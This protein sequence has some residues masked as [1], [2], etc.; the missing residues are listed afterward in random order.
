M[1]TGDWRCR[2]RGGI[3]RG[4]R[5]EGKS[6]P[7]ERIHSLPTRTTSTTNLLLLPILHSILHPFPALKATSTVRHD[8]SLSLQTDTKAFKK[9]LVMLCVFILKEYNKK[10]IKLRKPYMESLWCI[11]C[12][13]ENLPVMACK[14]LK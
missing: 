1:V 3:G 7:N 12:G 6:V 10:L 5:N 14:R 2:G 11:W 13:L 8:G 9:S 4:G